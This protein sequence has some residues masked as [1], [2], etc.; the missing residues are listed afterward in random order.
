MIAV[1]CLCRTLLYPDWYKKCEYQILRTQQVKRLE[2]LWNVCECLGNSLLCQHM[3]PPIPYSSGELLL[4]SCLG[5][6]YLPL[7]LR[8]NYFITSVLEHFAL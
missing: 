1:L 6:R 7:K 3:V 8:S 5:N 2:G 4:A